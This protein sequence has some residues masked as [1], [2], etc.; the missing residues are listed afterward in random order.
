M[1]CIQQVIHVYLFDR[2]SHSSGIVGTLLTPDRSDSVYLG[3]HTSSAV[4]FSVL[5]YLYG[6]FAV[7]SFPVHRARDLSG[8]SPMLYQ[9]DQCTHEKTTIILLFPRCYYEPLKQHMY[10]FS[11]RVYCIR[12]FCS[13]MRFPLAA[14]TTP[15]FGPTCAATSSF[16]VLGF[17]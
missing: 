1:S 17:I 14:V 11:V 6:T 5:R 16:H 15:G 7:Y 10:K 3:Q 4:W 8:T 2:F 9:W 12:V 13:L